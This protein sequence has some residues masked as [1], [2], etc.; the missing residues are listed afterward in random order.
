MV[1]MDNQYAFLRPHARTL[2]IVPLLYLLG[3]F[4]AR[5]SGFVFSYQY[6]IAVVAS[7]LASFMFD[8]E[9]ISSNRLLGK[10]FPDFNRISLFIYPV[11]LAAAL[12]LVSKYAARAPVYY[13]HF[14][15]MD[16]M[17]RSELFVL[18][19]VVAVPATEILFRGYLQHV[20]MHIFGSVSG[21]V[22]AGLTYAGFF[23]VLTRN[24][25]LL[26]TAAA[27]AGL[28][29]FLYYRHQSVV[30]TII[31]H[32]ILVLALFIFRF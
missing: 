31:A 9:I 25:W 22:L 13:L 27:I 7:I 6:T 23:L 1:Q 30:S 14:S 29:S 3:Y 4:M 8:R 32:V 11:L 10:N 21:S 5:H 16:G 17:P 2:L 19:I 15:S 26:L 12:I 24:I 18:M 28:L 20:M